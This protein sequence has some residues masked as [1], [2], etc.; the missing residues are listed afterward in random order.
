MSISQ[1]TVSQFTHHAYFYEVLELS[2]PKNNLQKCR[3]GIHK[4]L[5]FWAITFA[6]RVR[7]FYKLNTVQPLNTRKTI[8]KIVDKS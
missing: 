5:A 7:F 8:Q 6:A 2:K 4:P 3:L 1:E